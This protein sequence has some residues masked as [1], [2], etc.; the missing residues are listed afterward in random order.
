MTKCVHRPSRVPGSRHAWRSWA[1]ASPALTARDGGTKSG[2]S[3]STEKD[4]TATPIPTQPA[5]RKDAL[6]PAAPSRATSGMAAAIWPSWPRMPV[7]WMI[8][9]ARPGGNHRGTSRSTLMKVIA[10]PAPTST[11]PST[12]SPTE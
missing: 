4:T 12:A 5:T 6:H 11:R 10:S 9:G 7:S 2:G 1:R 8:S 3:A